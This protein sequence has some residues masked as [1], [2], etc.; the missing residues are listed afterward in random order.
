MRCKNKHGRE[1]TRARIRTQRRNN[2]GDNTSRE[3]ER[4]IDEHLHVKTE[5]KSN[6]HELQRENTLIPSRPGKLI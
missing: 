1:R 6:D 2:Y 3:E 4:K 5:K